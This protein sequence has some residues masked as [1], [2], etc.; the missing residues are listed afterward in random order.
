[1]SALRHVDAHFTCETLVGSSPGWI[2]KL[3]AETSLIS[4]LPISD[5]RCCAA[6][7]ESYMGSLCSRFDVCVEFEIVLEHRYQLLA[8]MG[9]LSIQRFAH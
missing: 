4:A 7:A 2:G 5:G 1:M 6:N 9:R 3:S 8:R